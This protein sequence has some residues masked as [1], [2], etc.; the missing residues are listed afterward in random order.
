VPSARSNIVSPF[1][2]KI[3]RIVR[4][5]VG[6]EPLESA[7]A[8]IAT[9]D[10]RPATLSRTAVDLITESLIRGCILFLA[11]TGGWRRQRFLRDGKPREG[12]LWQRTPPADLA[13]EFSRQTMELI[14][15]L[16]TASQSELDVDQ[17]ESTPADRL[18]YFLAYRA[19]READ[20]G[21]ALGLRPAFAANG[22][23]RLAFP[24]DFVTATSDANF[25][26]WL[27]GIGAIL[28][29]ALEPWLAERW[30]VL[31]RSKVEIGD[32]ATL[33]ALGR[34]QERQ[35]TAFSNAALAAGRPDLIRFMLQ[36]AGAVMPAGVTADRFSGGLQGTGPLRLAERLD[37]LRHSLAVA[38][39]LLRLRD[40]ERQVRTIGYL[41]EGY[42]AAQLWLSD[43]EELGSDDV[44]QRA[45]A[46]IGE[47]EPL[48]V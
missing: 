41:D 36:V 27:E 34:E 47:I 13:L 11:R 48:K 30:T 6:A 44:C 17:A 15:W 32:W 8:D 3:L 28:L 18:V 42:S 23:V 24:D 46:I 33:A 10:S 2:G 16:A 38:R 40:Y 43:W 39:F 31:E 4:A 14:L 25:A 26:P 29:E 21:P 37:V 5:V 7:L 20:S 35:L 19:F 12:R 22:L 1:E 9:R 45:E